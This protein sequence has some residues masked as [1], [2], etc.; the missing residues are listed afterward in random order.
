MC[1]KCVQGTWESNRVSYEPRVFREQFPLVKIFIQHLIY[2]REL[3]RLY[4]DEG[5]ESPFWASTIYA[6]ATQAVTFSCM[7]FG[8]DGLT[9]CT[10]KTYRRAMRPIFGKVFVNVLSGKLVPLRKVGMLTGKRSWR[11]VTSTLLIANSNI[12]NQSQL[13]IRRLKLLMSMIL[14]FEILSP[15]TF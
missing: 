7:V 8:R 15:Q 11:F 12:T 3:G 10:G 2:Y 14:G 9:R 4:H 6:H 13:W 1:P 5:L